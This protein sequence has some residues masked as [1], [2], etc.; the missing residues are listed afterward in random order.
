MSYELRIVVVR[1]RS[2]VRNGRNDP[3]FSAL[4]GSKLTA[5]SSLLTAH[6]SLLTAH[7]SYTIE[8][9]HGTRTG[10]TALSSVFGRGL[11]YGRGSPSGRTNCRRA[12]TGRCRGRK[13]TSRA[14]SWPGPPG[15]SGA[16]VR[17]IDSQPDSCQRVYF[18]D[19][20]HHLD[21]VVL[22]ASLPANLR[23]LTRPVAAK[24][25]W[26]RGRIRK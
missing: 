5:D 15:C 22:W 20:A 26:I 24:D 9:R 2:R 8:G 3:L 1:V 4:E 12:S 19:H 25:Y 13:P 23:R 6:S 17:W 16:S 7:G 11:G 14:P 10:T 21:A 18:A